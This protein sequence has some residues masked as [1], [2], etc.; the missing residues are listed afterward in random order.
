[1]MGMGMYGMHNP[2]MQGIMS[3]LHGLDSNS[4]KSKKKKSEDKKPAPAAAA[5]QALGGAIAVPVPVPA[6][7]PP[8]PEPKK[9]SEDDSHDDHDAAENLYA[10]GLKAGLRLANGLP[11]DEHGPVNPVNPLMASGMG[12]GMMHPLMHGAMGM[13]MMHSPWYMLAHPAM[14][15]GMHVYNA[16]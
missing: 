4:K 12:M 8:A 9:D 7:A 14:F 5:P 10:K 15:P 6:P 16:V 1:M 13:H 3:G 2:L 11:I